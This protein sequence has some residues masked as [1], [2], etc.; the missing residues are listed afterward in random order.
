MAYMA[1]MVWFQCVFVA[2]TLILL[3]G[4]VVVRMNF[5]AWIA[6]VPLWLTLSYTVGAF[7][8]WGVMVYS[9]GYVIHLVMVQKH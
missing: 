5:E 3:A 4:S 1:S 9:D 7:S 2:I 8:L 6:F